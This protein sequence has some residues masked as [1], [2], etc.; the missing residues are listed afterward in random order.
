MIEQTNL[1]TIF[2]SL[3]KAF[4][5]LNNMKNYKKNYQSLKNII[6]VCILRGT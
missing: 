5:L 4:I 6:V 2:C 1:K 3:D